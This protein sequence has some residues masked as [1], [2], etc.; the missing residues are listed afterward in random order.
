M[1]YLPQLKTI[2][3]LRNPSFINFCE[4]RTCSWNVFLN[5]WSVFSDKPLFYYIFI[6]HRCMSEYLI[7]DQLFLPLRFFFSLLLWA[8]VWLVELKCL[9]CFWL[10]RKLVTWNPRKNRLPVLPNKNVVVVRLFFPSRSCLFQTVFCTLVLFRG[11]GTVF[12]RGSGFS[13]RA[14]QIRRSVAFLPNLSIQRF[15]FCFPQL[16]VYS[17]LFF[18]RVGCQTKYLNCQCLSHSLLKLP[19]KH[20][21]TMIFPPI[22][23]S[24]SS[25]CRD[26]P[27][28]LVLQALSLQ[29]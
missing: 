24:V 3:F 12:G 1:K 26:L 28:A 25:S 9:S 27:F 14:S 2:F 6:P 22:F 4:I 20:L 16:H 8:I 29:H 18:W 11:S 10:T 5:K 15:Q 17:W 21:R 7:G 19:P 23:R 13:L